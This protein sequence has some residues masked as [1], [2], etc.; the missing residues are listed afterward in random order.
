M[1]GL[2]GMSAALWMPSILSQEAF[3][4]L[5]QQIVCA[6]VCELLGKMGGLLQGE[7]YTFLKCR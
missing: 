5:I 6:C 4:A 2:M 7:F 3:L 1:N